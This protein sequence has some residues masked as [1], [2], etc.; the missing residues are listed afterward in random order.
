MAPEELPPTCCPFCLDDCSPLLVNEAWAGQ[1]QSACAHGACEAC[2]RRWVET[3]LPRCRGERQLRLRCFGP[4]CRK[5]L[6]QKL[7]LH[8]SSK[9]RQIADALDQR[10]DLERNRLY[11]EDLRVDCP[12]PTCVGLG[13]LEFETVMCFLCETRWHPRRDQL[14]SI[15]VGFELPATVKPCPRCRVLIEKDGGCDHMKCQCGHDFMW[16]TLEMW[17]P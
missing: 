15:K 10:F 14:K 12:N 13:Y 9:A 2:L 6:A 1:W 3:Q 11:P 4:H 16:S 8:V 5:T 17:T 7:V